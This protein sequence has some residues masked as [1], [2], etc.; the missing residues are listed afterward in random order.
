MDILAN[1]FDKPSERAFTAVPNS[2]PKLPP[3]LSAVFPPKKGL[4]I[5]GD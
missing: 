4:L 3:G 1:K 2:S 5:S